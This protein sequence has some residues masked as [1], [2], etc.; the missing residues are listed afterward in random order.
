MAT[1]QLRKQEDAARASTG[2]WMNLMWAV[3]FAAI[4]IGVAKR[5]HA[6][7]QLMR[8]GGAAIAAVGAY[9]LILP[10]TGG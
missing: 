2:F 7:A 8:V 6:G 9:F 4:L 3:S 10:L 5:W 1:E